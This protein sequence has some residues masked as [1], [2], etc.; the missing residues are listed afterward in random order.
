VDK[1]F[2]AFPLQADKHAPTE[3]VHPQMTQ[4]APMRIRTGSDD[5]TRS[6]N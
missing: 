5:G 2:H 4:I 6:G 1:A 3:E